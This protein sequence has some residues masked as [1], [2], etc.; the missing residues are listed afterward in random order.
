M[1]LVNHEEEK[2]VQKISITLYLKIKKDLYQTIFNI[3]Y[4]LS[5]V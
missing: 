5:L 4:M 3:E 1:C 2:V